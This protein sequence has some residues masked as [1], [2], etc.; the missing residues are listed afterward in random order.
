MAARSYGRGLSGFCLYIKTKTDMF[1]SFRDC[2]G[3]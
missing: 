2:P 1:E 3:L